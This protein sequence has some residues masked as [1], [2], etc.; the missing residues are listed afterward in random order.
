MR[1]NKIS[2]KR[3][4]E[5][6]IALRTFA[7]ATNFNYIYSVKNATGK[8]TF[9]RLLLY[10][11]GFSI[12][13]TR[14]VSF[15]EFTVEIEIEHK[16]VTFTVK[17]E[18][19]KIWVNGSEMILPSDTHIAHSIIFDE[20]S[21]DLID[22]LLGAIYIDQDRGWTLL[23]RGTQIGKIRFYIE[24][25][26]HGLKGKD[27]DIE[28][29]V[30]LRKLDDELERYRQ[31]KAVAEY[32][33]QAIE[34]TGEMNL[35]KGEVA[36]DTHTEEL[37]SGR[38]ELQY[39]KQSI[40]KKIRFL[41]R[42]IADD[43]KFVEWLES[44]NII[45]RGTNGELIPVTHDTIENYSDNTELNKIEVRR[46][47]IALRKVTEA[48]AAIDEEINSQPM[49]LGGET[50]LQT[51][52]R[53]IADVPV[54]F[55]A[56]E[57]TIKK[58]TKEQMRLREILRESARTQNIWAG[59]LNEYILAYAKELSIDEY[60][61]T[62][63]YFLFKDIKSISG[64]IYHKMVFI[65]RI[66]YNRVLSE[67]LGYKVPFFIDSPNGREVEKSAVDA[68]IA[69]LERDFS[70]TQIFIASIFNFIKQTANNKKIV[71]DGRLFN[72]VTGQK[73]IFDLLDGGYDSP[74]DDGD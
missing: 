30:A 27:C 54:D 63:D 74:T 58:L 45:V 50:I 56:V 19:R 49:F 38:R 29:K 66:S 55:T 25:F 51:F 4:S 28:I 9:M 37:Q 14:K 17:R 42:T 8:S 21:F 36:F 73:S 18:S 48:I 2:F 6:D 12:P 62:G 70:E 15:E 43:K 46:E 20:D 44:H 33:E 22:N 52:E 35:D 53:R 24:E 57:N 7:F 3:K 69:I 1:I 10:S 67:K 72:I 11:L 40:E 39:E 32:K 71:M 41:E 60:L 59:K 47:Q 13:N 23:N 31:M 5:P 61:D 65:F 68:M 34:A 64:A 16:G 26:L